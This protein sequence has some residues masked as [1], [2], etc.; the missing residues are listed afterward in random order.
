M[1][2]LKYTGIPGSKFYAKQKNPPDYAIKSFWCS[3]KPE[4]NN[5]SHEESETGAK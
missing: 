1:Q 4:S 2:Y 5:I 3:N